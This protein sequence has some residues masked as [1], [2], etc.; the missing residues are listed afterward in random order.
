MGVCPKPRQ[1]AVPPAPPLLN[2][3]CGAF[4]GKATQESDFSEK[5]NEGNVGALPQTPAGGSAFCTS[6][7]ER[8]VRRVQGNYAGNSKI[9]HAARPS[10]RGADGVKAAF[11]GMGCGAPKVSA[12]SGRFSEPEAR[13]ETSRRPAGS[14]RRLSAARGLLSSE[15]RPLPPQK[16]VS[17]YCPNWLLRPATD[18]MGSENVI[19]PAGVSGP[20]VVVIA[21]M[22]AAFLFDSATMSTTSFSSASDTPRNFLA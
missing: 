7:F 10:L 20:V 19:A 15:R 16:T 1:E 18:E 9:T 14:M 21:R 12:A 5:R 4:K 13:H 17:P 22:M 11:L 2:A 3:P 8:A 6:A